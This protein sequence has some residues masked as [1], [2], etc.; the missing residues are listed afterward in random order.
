MQVIVDHMIAQ[1]FNLSV[2]TDN[3][4]LDYEGLP[5]GFGRLQISRQKTSRLPMMKQL[6]MQ[7]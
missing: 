7:C 6:H 4:I 5:R 3:Y 1:A 2:D